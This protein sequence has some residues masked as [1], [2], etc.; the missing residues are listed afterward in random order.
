MRAGFDQR[1]LEEMTVGYRKAAHWYLYAETLA[2]PEGL[3][4]DTLHLNR[5]MTNEQKRA[6]S[7]AWKQ[8]QAIRK[9]LFPEDD[10]GTS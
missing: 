10:D 8:G 1:A 7:D 3:P 5:E 4:S 9:V 6:V 2:G